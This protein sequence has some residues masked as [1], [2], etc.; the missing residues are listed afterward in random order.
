[1]HVVYVLQSAHGAA[2]V[3]RRRSLR[4][5]YLDVSE[6]QLKHRNINKV[7]YI[8][9]IEPTTINGNDLI[10]TSFNYN[11]LSCKLLSM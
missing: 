6:N 2:L 9:I 11:I 5:F 10:Y 3:S 4:K 1:M 7:S 8:P